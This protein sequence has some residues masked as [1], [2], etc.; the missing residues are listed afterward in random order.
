MKSLDVKKRRVALV[1]DESALLDLYTE[2]LG[3]A[4]EILT[5]ENPQK[6][7]SVLVTDEPLPF[8]ILMTDLNMPG[9]NGI[10]MIKSAQKKGFYFPSI[11][12]SGYLDKNSVF[13]AVDLGVYRLIEKPT[14]PDMVISAIEELLVEYEIRDTRNEIRQITCK[15]REYYTFV[16]LFITNNIP[17]AEAQNF[18][19]QVDQAGQVINQ[20]SF[21]K[22][23]DQLDTRL[24]KLLKSEN[25]LEEVRAKRYKNIA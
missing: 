14:S 18:S 19:L 24:E 16:R 5:F 10:E 17:A 2:I 6:F 3:H 9:M 20:E 1:D 23:L 22:L 21:D 13:A 12:L 25:I 8:D 11:L 4:Y 7:L 15:M